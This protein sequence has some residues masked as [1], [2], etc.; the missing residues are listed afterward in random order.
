MLEA[1]TERHHEFIV[2]GTV[3]SGKTNPLL[4]RLY[5]LH[6][7]IPNLVS[8]ICRKQRSDMRKSVIDQWEKEVLPYHPSHPLSPCTAFGGRNPSE[9]NWK[10]GGVTYVFGV[11]EA[12]LMLGAQFDCGYV[13]QSEQLTLA[14]WEFLSHRCGRSGNWYL[15]G[16][17]Y[18]QI[19]GDANPDVATH[20]IPERAKSNKLK[21]YQVGFKDNVL[22]YQ[23]SKWTKHGKKQTALLKRTM[24]GVRYR[25]LILG[26]WCSSEGLVF[27]EF[28]LKDHVV[29][30]LPPWVYGDPKTQWY[31]GIDYGHTEPFLACWFAY[32]KKT[33]VLISVK[34]WRMTNM[35]ISDHIKRIKEGSKDKNIVMRVSDHETE[36][37]HQLRAAGLDTEH[38]N[39]E[40][41]SILRGLDL[42]RI[43]LRDKRLLLCSDQLIE[44]DPILEERQAVRDGIEE[45]QGYHHKPVEKHTGDST[46]DDIPIKGNDHWIDVARYVIDKIDSRTIFPTD[47]ALASP[48]YTNWF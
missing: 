47:G 22:F 25:R 7:V 12:R 42:M 2:S 39:K 37:N 8:F 46:K 30:K 13:C 34:E 48:D 36:M 23:G 43:R 24:T 35:L 15:N 18:G 32:N 26:E 27:P 4:H 16:E 6:C 28:N 3:E 5:Q 33:D 11:E 10:N 17:R 1:M 14:D 44:R 19:F 31:L 20:W 45:M 41:G 40:K 21:H 29:D 38:A 9:Y